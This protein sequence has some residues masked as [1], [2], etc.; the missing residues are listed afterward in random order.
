M[1]LALKEIDIPERFRMEYGDLKELAQSIDKYGLLQP[2]VLTK[3]E[4]KPTLVAG[5]RRFLAMTQLKWES[6]PVYWLE[7]LNE[8][9]RR[10]I[11]LEENIKRKQFTWQE[12]VKAKEELVKLRQANRASLWGPSKVQKSVADELHESDSTLGRDLE[13]AQAMDKYP[14]LKLEESKTAAYKK[15]KQL[16]EKE[17]LEKFAQLVSGETEKARLW[18][19]DCVEELKKLKDGEINLVVTD[20]PWGVD[21]NS[22]EK[23]GGYIDDKKYDDSYRTAFGLVERVL[24]EV[25][26]VTSPGSHLYFFCATRFL[27][28]TVSLLSKRF[29][30]SPIP[31]VWWKR[32]AFNSNPLINFAPDYET[33]LFCRKGSRNL[34]KPSRSV[35]DIPVPSNKVHP[36]QK[37]VDLIKQLIDL[38]SVPGEVVLD[39]FAGSGVAVKA[40]LELG[41]KVV[42]IELNVEFYN[43]MLK[44][45]V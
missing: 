16:K 9:Q 42:A 12:E 44:E 7:E 33:I 17:V 38:S 32:Q 20:P 43:H 18:C 10:E 26:R 5:M 14:Q 35:F 6:C 22:E 23:Q 41:R 2:L 11:E 36:N 15:M 45:V 3:V 24:P 31:L 8:L 13:L 39:P 30:V 37:P 27:G 28:D 34:N 40:A 21:Y 19:G 4:G 29:H 1:R 25:D